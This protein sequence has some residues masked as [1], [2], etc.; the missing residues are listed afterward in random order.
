MKR[1]ISMIFKPLKAVAEISDEEPIFSGIFIFAISVLLGNI[2]LVRH[3]FVSWQAAVFNCFALVFLW[4]GVMVM[5]DLIL[6]GILKLLNSSP[7]KI[8]NMERFRKLIV[9]QLNIAVILIFRPVL[10]L[11][12]TNIISWVIVFVWGA[13]LILFTVVSLW[14]V[15][16]IKAAISIGVAVAAVFFGVKIFKPTNDSLYLKS[17]PVFFNLFA[18]CQ[19]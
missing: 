7:S 1:I 19:I 17:R 4:G 15:T 18:N 5:I 14:N 12:T 3:F 2:N 9:V 16:E 8:I 11:F 10:E 13:L 6:T